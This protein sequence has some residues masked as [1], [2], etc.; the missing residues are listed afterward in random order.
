M[1]TCQGIESPRR[2]LHSPLVAHDHSGDEETP[3]PSYRVHTVETAPEKS[4]AALEALQKN[5]GVVP[6]LA[7]TMAESPALL[8]GFLGAF[9]N[10]HGGTFSGGQRQA[11]LLANAVAN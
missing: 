6:N 2:P 11:L 5:F 10:F 9:D 1:L 3:M 8:N 7:A 4:R